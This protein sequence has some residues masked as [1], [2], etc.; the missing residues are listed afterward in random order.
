[1]QSKDT[2]ARILVVEDDGSMRDLLRLHLSNAGYQVT[3]TP[4]ATIAGRALLSSPYDLIITDIELPYLSGI[5]FASVLMADTTL[6]HIPVLLISAQ[7]RYREQAEALGA[8]F[9]AKPILKNDLLAAVS[10]ALEARAPRV[11]SDAPSEW[12]SEP[13]WVGETKEQATLRRAR[14]LAGGVSYLAHQLG[15]GSSLLDLMMAG[16]IQ[17]PDWVFERAAAVVAE[18]E[19]DNAPPRGLPEDWNSPHWALSMAQVN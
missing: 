11:A 15:V 10:A 13:M 2:K 4:D 14:D 9:L 7:E 17:T 1:M 3:V 19:R 18:A 12:R 8:T 5:E 16:V 6:P